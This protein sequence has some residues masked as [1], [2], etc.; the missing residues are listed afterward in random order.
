MILD[1]FAPSIAH[2]RRAQEWFHRYARMVASPRMV[3][4]LW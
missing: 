4:D 2:S 1:R 3:G